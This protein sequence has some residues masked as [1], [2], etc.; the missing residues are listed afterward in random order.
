MTANIE[1]IRNLIKEKRISRGLTMKDIAQKVGVS[2]ATI[3][4]WESGD[5]ENMKRDKIVKLADA[6]GV[7]PAVIMGWETPSNLITPAARR[8]PV[9]GVISCGCGISDDDFTGY[10]FVDNSVKADY[11]LRV[12]GDSMIDAGIQDGDYA[13]IQK[14][15]EL[16]DG[17]IYAVVEKCNAEAVLKKLYRTDGKVIL[18]SCNVSYA[19]IVKEGDEVCVVGELVG[20]YHAL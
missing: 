8:V 20:V 15:C 18:Q 10:F 19:P 14:D 16:V 6:L 13:F 9:L 11:C 5:I 17:K 3:S 1:E 2:E 4:R 7:S 12:S